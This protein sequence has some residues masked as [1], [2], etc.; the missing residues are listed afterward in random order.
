MDPGLDLPGEEGV[1]PGFLGV[2]A[3]KASRDQAGEGAPADQGPPGI[4]LGGG[5]DTRG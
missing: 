1:D 3:L 2:A 5:R 4:A